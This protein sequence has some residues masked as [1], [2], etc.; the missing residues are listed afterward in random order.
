MQSR[1]PAGQPHLQL[2]QRGRGNGLSREPHAVGLALLQQ[3]LR[4]QQLALV[5]AKRLDLWGTAR[6]KR[7]RKA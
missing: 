5:G 1:Q 3:L 7:G 6:R 2:A 4:H